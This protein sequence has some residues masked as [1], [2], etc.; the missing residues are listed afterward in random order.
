MSISIELWRFDHSK[1]SPKKYMT[2]VSRGFALHWNA[3][4]PSIFASPNI[5]ETC[6]K[7]W[8]NREGMERWIYMYPYH[9]GNIR[10]FWK[11]Q[12]KTCFYRH[13]F[14]PKNIEKTQGTLWW[15]PSPKTTHS[16]GNSF[17]YPRHSNTTRILSVHF[18]LIIRHHLQRV[19]PL[20][21]R[22]MMI[23]PAGN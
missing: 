6:S 7:K 16:P 21:P 10:S 20:Y 12:R 13:D 4:N 19:A 3:T 15:K 14:A 17:W 8:K 23:I 5:W 11:Y 1:S 18:A 22:T 2:G 9:N